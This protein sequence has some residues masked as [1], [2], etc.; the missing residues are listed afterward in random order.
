[1]ATAKKVKADTELC[2]CSE[3]NNIMCPVF[4]QH[5]DVSLLFSP[6]GR[7]EIMKR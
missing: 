7:P 2:L 3:K 5:N 4:S 6:G 1:M